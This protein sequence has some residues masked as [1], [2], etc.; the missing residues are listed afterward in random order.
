[1]F[2][3]ISKNTQ[4]LGVRGNHQNSLTKINPKR[5]EWSTN[6]Y[7]TVRPYSFMLKDDKTEI[8]KG[9]MIY[10]QT[11]TGNIVKQIIQGPN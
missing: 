3:I 6:M 1:M 11:S 8:Q 4:K 2:A 7:T 10:I 5:Y 9:N